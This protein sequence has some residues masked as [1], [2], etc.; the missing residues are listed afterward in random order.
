MKGFYSIIICVLIAAG[1]A[2]GYD[3]PEIIVVIEPEPSTP[4]FADDFC[5]IGDQNDDGC[6]DLLVNHEPFLHGYGDYEFVNQVKLYW[7]GEEM[8]SEADMIFGIEEERTTFGDHLNYLGAIEEGQ[9]PFIAIGYRYYENGFDDVSDKRLYLFEGG[10]NLDDSVDRVERRGD[11]EDSE[12]PIIGWGRNTLPADLNGDGFHDLFAAQRDSV[13]EYSRLQ[14]YF[15][16]EELDTI[17]DWNVWIPSRFYYI[18]GIDYSSGFDINGD[19]C[20]DVLSR[21]PVNEGG[22]W[23][24]MYLGGDPMD[25]TALFTFRE[26]HFRG[27]FTQTSMDQGFSL[28]PDVNGDGYDDWGIYFQ[29]RYGEYEN[30]GYYIF[31]GGEDPDLEPDLILEGIHHQWTDTGD[32]TGGD[33]NGDGYGDIV[34]GHSAHFDSDFGEVCI[35]FGSRWMDGEADIVVDNERD[36]GGRYRSIG[37]HVGAVGDYNG[38][39]V[40]DFIAKTSYRRGARLIIFAG[41]RDWEVVVKSECSP[42]TYLLSLIVHPNPF[43]NEVMISY[44]V[45]FTDRVR[46]SV[47][48]IRGRLVAT[49]EDNLVN[50][51]Y[52]ELTWTNRTA[53]VYFIVLKSGDL[54]TVRKLVC[55][56]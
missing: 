20:D 23:Y 27:R 32:L 12:G 1:S 37:E 24:Y 14:V 56:P 3:L 46:L 31:F 33:L 51:G 47:Y 35:H 2:V 40:D 4:R 42:Q 36:L 8:D 7:G 9:Y 39:G 41:N 17:P 6:D 34:T 28:L 53:G 11:D 49:L 22:R 55:I 50:W 44:G 43:N 26:N 30:D 10:E 45:P 5:W 15:G 52:H 13:N 38:D 25:T 19:G 48:D 18:G 54:Q 21:F 29:E 16:G